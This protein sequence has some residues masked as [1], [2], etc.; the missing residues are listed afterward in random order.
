MEISSGT[1]LP[2]AFTQTAIIS[3]IPSDIKPSPVSVNPDVVCLGEP[4]TLTSST[5]YTNMPNFLDQGAFDNASITEHGWRVRR[6]GDPTDIGFDTD[7]NNTRPDRWKRATRHQ[8]TTADINSPY[9][10]RED[11]Y[12]SSGGALSLIHI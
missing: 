7:A 9:T 10:T 8:F 2:H 5:G 1:C 6:N 3:V 11:L 4:V 12:I